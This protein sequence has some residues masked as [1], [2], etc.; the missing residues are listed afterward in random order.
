[1]N[2][3][4][5]VAGSLLIR[6]A[7]AGATIQA[8]TWAAGIST[9]WWPAPSPAVPWRWHRTTAIRPVSIPGVRGR[10]ADDDKDTYGRPAHRAVL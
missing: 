10:D 7:R 1:M 5:A 6:Y 4:R 8:S 2:K 9:A 3:F